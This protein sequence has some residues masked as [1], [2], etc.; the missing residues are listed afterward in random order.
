MVRLC[1]TY[2][3]PL[4]I[5][6]K[7]LAMAPKCLLTSCALVEKQ[8]VIDNLRRVSSSALWWCASVANGGCT[9]VGRVEF[10]LFYVEVNIVISPK[11]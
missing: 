11:P 9:H 1:C 3:D 5:H 8:E 2:E 10:A 7:G 4:P 6:L